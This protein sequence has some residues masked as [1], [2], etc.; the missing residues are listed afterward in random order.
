MQTQKRTPSHNAPV[1]K[2]AASLTTK[3]EAE[4]TSKPV[5]IDVQALRHVAG[6]NTDLPKKY[7]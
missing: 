6:G 3:R 1:N 2:R 4:Q 5:E 7:W